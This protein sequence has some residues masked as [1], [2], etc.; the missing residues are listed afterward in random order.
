MEKRNQVSSF[1]GLRARRVLPCASFPSF[2]LSSLLVACE[3][4]GAGDRKP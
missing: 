1:I 4:E 3:G 2:L